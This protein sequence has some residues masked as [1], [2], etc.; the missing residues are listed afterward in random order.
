MPAYS[1]FEILRRIDN[2]YL[3][4]YAK[5]HNLFKDLNIEKL[6]QTGIEPVNDAIQKLD[7]AQRQKVE[8]DLRHI[9][10]MADKRRI[11]YLFE[12]IKNE[13]LSLPDFQKRRANF[14]K[15]MWAFLEHPAIFKNVL[16]YS[17]PFTQNRHWY[18][19]QHPNSKP[20]LEKTDRTGLREAIKVF[21]QN[22]DGRGELR[23]LNTTK[24]RTS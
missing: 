19:F 8:K 23:R 5:E 20:H 7:P 9:A 1:P 24:K 16:Y 14:D 11:Q 2:K 4:Q 17:F 15:A 3:A 10:T 6:P 12:A 22:Y 21:F 13:G 18:K